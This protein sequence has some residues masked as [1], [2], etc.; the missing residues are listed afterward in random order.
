MIPATMPAKR[1]AIVTGANR[2]LGLEIAR[3]LMRNDVFVVAGCRDEAKCATAMEALAAEGDN[4]A[5][6][7]LDVN[8]TKVAAAFVDQVSR[9]HGT[10]TILV[11]NAGVRFEE[12]ESRVTDLST[13]YWRATFETNVFGALRMCREV[14]PHME[15]MRYGRVVNISSGMGQ[16]HQMGAGS[17]AYR[18]SKAALNAL[19]CTL[20]AEVKGTGILVNSM[21]PGWVRTDMGGEGAPR[22]VEEGA[23]T[24]VWLCLL[25]SSG[26]TG[27]FFRDR[28]PIPW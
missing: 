4:A 6:L 18:V 15:K 8:D 22:T 5:A 27:Q 11:N 12:H 3:Q 2:G 21:S 9:Q 19:T 20:A 17:P 25:P 10:P 23:E 1:T 26:P 14:I 28:Q 24:A 16:M 13:A 7:V